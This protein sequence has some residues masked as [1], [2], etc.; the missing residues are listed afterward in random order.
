M[1]AYSSVVVR[2]VIRGVMLQVPLLALEACVLA[3]NS[4]VDLAQ[5]GADIIREA[6]RFSPEL[7]AAA[8]VWRSIEFNY[9]AVD[10]V[11]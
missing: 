11:D 1:L 4:G 5:R 10:T 3:R 8:E 9:K 2:W 7:A 6:C